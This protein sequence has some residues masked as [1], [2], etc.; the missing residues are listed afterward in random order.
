MI[1]NQTNENNLKRKKFKKIFKK[2]IGKTYYE[3]IDLNLINLEENEGVFNFDNLIK[4]SKL[5]YYGLNIYH[6]M[7]LEE[8]LNFVQKIV[9]FTKIKIKKSILADKNKYILHISDISKILKIKIIDN[10]RTNSDLKNNIDNY[11]TEKKIPAENILNFLNI[12]KLYSKEN[13]NGNF[14]IYDN[15]NSLE[16]PDIID[17]YDLIIEIYRL[18]K[19]NN[20]IYSENYLEKFLKNKDEEKNLSD[21]E[22]SIDPNLQIKENNK[23][24][25]TNLVIVK[26]IVLSGTNLTIFDKPLSFK[27]NSYF[28]F[29]W[30]EETF[31][32]NC[33]F[34]NSN[35]E[36]IQEIEIKIPIN[37]NFSNLLIE[38]LSKNISISVFSKNI[39]ESDEIKDYNLN[40]L[41]D[42][43]NYNNNILN[44]FSILNNI[45]KENSENFKQDD[46]IGETNIC[47]LEIIQQFLNNYNLKY[48]HDGFYHI[49]NSR[50]NIVGQIHLKIIIDEMILSSI[51]E[52]NK[53]NNNFI[54]NLSQKNFFT[55]TQNLKKKNL[56]Y[57]GNTNNSLKNTFNNKNSDLLISNFSYN[58]N[59][60]KYDYDYPNL[61]SNGN[62]NFTNFSN[63]NIKN[64]N[65]NFKLIDSDLVKEKENNI[66]INKQNIDELDTNNLWKIIEDNQVQLF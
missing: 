59:N 9:N 20:K 49:Y 11:N 19:L 58:R 4:F 41:T 8:N 46:F 30:G 21:S 13:N 51:K 22:N 37:K 33:I 40:N 34:N 38:K 5:F 36:W 17:L 53:N 50:E 65:L 1:K 48:E 32:S 43:Y 63:Q 52:N 16:T 28:K 42:N 61:V 10:F 54:G 45:N 64:S 14:S 23:I 7:C 55:E 47:I 44:H 39:V 27:P 3:Y 56:S 2:L 35:P 18:N 62:F 29:I 12:F 31:I 24:F 6:S 57:V 15:M 66:L 25:E 60:Y 26:V